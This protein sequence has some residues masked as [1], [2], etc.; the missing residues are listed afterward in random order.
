M[1]R[2]EFDALL[3]EYRVQPVGDGYIDCICPWDTV[4]GFMD[5]MTELEVRLTEFTWWCHVTEGHKP[6]GMGG[7]VDRYG[8][9]WYSEMEMGRTYEFPSNGGMK[10]FLLEVWPE[11]RGERT[12]FVPAFWLRFPEEWGWGN[13][14]GDPGGWVPEQRI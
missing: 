2:A 6:C 13:E 7:P 4:A 9:G 5:R 11:R 8:D 10:R 1:T 14:R 3:K 12:C